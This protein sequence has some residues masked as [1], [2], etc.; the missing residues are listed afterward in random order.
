MQNACLIDELTSNLNLFLQEACENNL[1]DEVKLLMNYGADPS[2]EDKW[3]DSR[4]AI[5]VAVE[6][7]HI[8]ILA[9]LLERA[10]VINY[11]LENSMKNEDNVNCKVMNS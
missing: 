1:M 7:G 2:V 9:L 5:T 10:S 4:S 11:K 3:N 8:H 6:N